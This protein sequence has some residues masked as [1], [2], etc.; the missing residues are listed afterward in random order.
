MCDFS[1]PSLFCLNI[2]QRIFC[3]DGALGVQFILTHLLSLKPV[4]WCKY[5]WVA[6]TAFDR[7]CQYFLLNPSIS[8]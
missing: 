6:A 3:E 1:S 5:S 2:K 4:V 7:K 8:L